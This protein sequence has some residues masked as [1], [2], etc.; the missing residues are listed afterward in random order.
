MPS[1]PHPA[2]LEI[3]LRLELQKVTLIGLTTPTQ[4][5][6]REEL[7]CNGTPQPIC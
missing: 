3:I 6:Y 7:G 4:T 1:W 5:A 2:A